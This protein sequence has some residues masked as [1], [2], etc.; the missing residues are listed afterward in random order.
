[1]IRATAPKVSQSPYSTPINSRMV[2]LLCLAHD[3][4]S[5]A[6]LAALIAEDLA[7]RRLPEADQLKS[8]LAPRHRPLPADVP[9]ALTVLASF[10]ALL[11]MRA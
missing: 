11:E 8:R 6:E 10:D 4:A 5:E 3:E 1:M 7:A 2:D 9:V